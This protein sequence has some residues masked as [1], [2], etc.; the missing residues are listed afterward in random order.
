MRRNIDTLLTRLLPPTPR[1]FRTTLVTNAGT[2]SAAVEERVT[3]AG[4]TTE[5][6]RPLGLD[7]PDQVFSLS[8]V[9]IP[10]P[11]DDSLY[12]MTPNLSDDFGIHL[13]AMSVRGERGTLIVSMDALI[14]MSSNPFFPYL[15]GRIEAGMNPGP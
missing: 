7:Y 4:A 11:L 14:R 9:A 10:F 12:G 13:G 1:H 8:H 3:E 2:G 15:L 5:T 6:V